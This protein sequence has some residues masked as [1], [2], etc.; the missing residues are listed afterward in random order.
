MDVLK[1]INSKK[2]SL[3]LRLFIISLFCVSIY[4]TYPTKKSQKEGSKS[5]YHFDRESEIV[6]VIQRLFR[7]G[8]NVPF[9]IVKEKEFSID[10]TTYCKLEI[11]D[12]VYKEAN[13]DFYFIFR[14]NVLIDSSN[15]R[16]YYLR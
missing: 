15:I 13:S 5:L 1:K 9:I 3:F 14:K 4:I 2:F 6:G 12:S 16:D 10:D 11:G 8:H 7:G